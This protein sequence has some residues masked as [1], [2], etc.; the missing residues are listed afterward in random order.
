MGWF[1]SAWK[2]AN[3]FNIVEDIW[4]D[5]TGSTAKKRAN[6]TNIR[7][8][9]EN[10]DFEE[11]MSSTEVQRRV[12]DLQN[13]GLNPMLAYSGAASSP[14]TSAATV[15]PEDSHTLQNLMAVNS[16]RANSLQREQIQAQTAL[17]NNQARG[18]AIDNQAKEATLPFSASNAK[19][20]NEKLN[21][22]M[23]ETRQRVLRL[24]Q[25]ADLTK[26]AI[27]SGKLSNDQKEKINSIEVEIQ[28]LEQRAR[29]LGIP[30]KQW[31]ATWYSSPIGG[32]GKI[33]N[34]SK[35]VIQIIHLLRGK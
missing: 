3:P 18:V 13:A 7:L 20:S 15:E 8:A 19:M 4:G 9:Q 6:E 28:K 31:E 34:M 1:H 5:F 27:R 23:N 25:E 24:I 29:E 14:N 10:R 12:N 22:E 35:D 2:K 21:Y 16:A 32:G 30:E 33:A 11:R 26:E 17:I